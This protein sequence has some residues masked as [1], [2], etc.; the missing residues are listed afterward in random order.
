MLETPGSS[1]HRFL[2]LLQIPGI[3]GFLSVHCSDTLFLE[4]EYRIE[5]LLWDLLLFIVENC[6]HSMATLI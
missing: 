3:L 5:H 1:E 4:L 6:C 2:N